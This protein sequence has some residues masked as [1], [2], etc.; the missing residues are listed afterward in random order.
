MNSMIITN[1]RGISTIHHCSGCVT[2]YPKN[3]EG[4]EANNETIPIYYSLRHARDV[5]WR[6]TSSVLFCPPELDYVWVCPDCSKRH[7]K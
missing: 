3:G 7:L 2:R 1:D 4:T 6:S 5:G